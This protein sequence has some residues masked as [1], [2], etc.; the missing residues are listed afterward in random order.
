[1]AATEALVVTEALDINPAPAEYETG[2]GLLEEHLC[3]GAWHIHSTLCFAK[4]A[5]AQIEVARSEVCVQ[6]PQVSAHE[7][8]APR[9]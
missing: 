7:T 5:E 8:E 2:L 6:A 1:M 4:H 3:A 9:L